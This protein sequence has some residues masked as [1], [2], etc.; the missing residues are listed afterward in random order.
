MVKG[1]TYSI[2]GDYDCYQYALAE[3]VN[4]I[5]K[6]EFLLEKLW[7]LNQARIIIVESIEACNSLRPH[8]S[9]GYKMPDAVHQAF[10]I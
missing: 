7:D 1:I 3:R 6:Q 10:I 2:I 5:L 9:L 4:G 8:L